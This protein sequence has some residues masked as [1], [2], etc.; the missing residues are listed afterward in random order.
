MSF[1][2]VQKYFAFIQKDFERFST[3][4]NFVAIVTRLFAGPNRNLKKAMAGPLLCFIK[5]GWIVSVR[6]FKN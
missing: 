2:S 3:F 6:T 1:A 4:F 5:T